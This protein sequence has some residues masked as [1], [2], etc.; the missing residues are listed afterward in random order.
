MALC[1]Q[2]CI[3]AGDAQS[4][5]LGSPGQ[6]LPLL[7]TQFWQKALF[8]SFY[9]KLI[10]CNPMY[11]VFRF[12]DCLGLGTKLNWLWTVCTGLVK[13]HV[14][15]DVSFPCTLQMQQF[16]WS[17][18]LEIWKCCMQ[19]FEGFTFLQKVAN[20]P[21][22]DK[23]IISIIYHA[24]ISFRKCFKGRK[25]CSLDIYNGQLQ[26]KRNSKFSQ[27]TQQAEGQVFLSTWSGL[28]PVRSTVDSRRYLS[29]EFV[30]MLPE[31]KS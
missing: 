14:S 22:T 10:L 6:V 21:F 29:K 5:S 2:G 19:F 9:V 3:R 7:S 31:S 26:Q 27:G 28:S 18:D 17:R 12:P 4:T 16:H 15:Q 13:S 11:T 30:K 25:I 8:F 20:N 24:N 1:H 23:H